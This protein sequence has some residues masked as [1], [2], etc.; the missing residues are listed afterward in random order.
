M[1]FLGTLLGEIDTSGAQELILAFF[2]YL[3]E[4]DI[5]EINFDYLGQLLTL[6]A[7]IWNPIWAMV[8]EWLGDV[9]GF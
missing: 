7:P 6:I 4:F 5:K 3:S 9:F 8:N 1:D 2:K